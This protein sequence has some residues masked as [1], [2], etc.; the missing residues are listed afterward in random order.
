[1]D[2]WAGD[3]QLLARRDCSRSM[4]LGRMIAEFVEN[5]GIRD[6]YNAHCIF[7]TKIG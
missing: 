2:E 7:W 1:M 4:G 3:F 5:S 6:R